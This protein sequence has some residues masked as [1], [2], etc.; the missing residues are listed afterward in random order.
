MTRTRVLIMGAAGRDFHNFN[1]VFREDPAFEVIAFTAT[2]IPNIDG[3]MYP[4]E[5]AGALYPEGIRIFPE[6]DLL[7]LIRD[8]RIDDVVFSYSDVPH[9]YVMHQASRVLAA[10]ANFRLL[11]PRATQLPSS[12][13]ADHAPRRRHPARAGLQGRGGASPDALRKP[14]RADGA[15]VRRL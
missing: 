8:L 12:K 4:A 10:G 14:D 15:A 2:E 5:L 7:E 9:T 13:P 3:R 1:T 11:G 6:G